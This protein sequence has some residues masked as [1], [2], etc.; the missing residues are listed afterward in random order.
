MTEHWLAVS[1][2]QKG[3]EAGRFQ[4]SFLRHTWCP[5]PAA[6]VLDQ[7]AVQGTGSDHRKGMSLLSYYSALGLID[8]KYSNSE[9]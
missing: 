7:K 5:H 1:K 6:F 2:H 9:T 3:W 8:I 4:I